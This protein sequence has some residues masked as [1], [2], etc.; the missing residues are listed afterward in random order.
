MVLH[1]VVQPSM[2]EINGVSTRGKV[3]R[4]YDLPHVKG[5]ASRNAI[6]LETVQIIAG[7]IRDD[8]DKRVNVREH[9]SEDEVQDRVDVHR[10]GRRRF[11]AKPESDKKPWKR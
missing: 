11:Q 3:G 1:L 4:R 8:D 10:L 9:V 5:P 2:E 6:S 7:M